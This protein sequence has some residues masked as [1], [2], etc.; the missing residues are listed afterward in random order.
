MELAAIASEKIEPQFVNVGLVVS[1]VTYEP[2]DVDH[3]QAE[4][5]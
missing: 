3:D 1:Q 2:S 4:L 5:D